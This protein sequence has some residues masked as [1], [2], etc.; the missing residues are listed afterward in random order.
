VDFI[1]DEAQTDAAEIS[2]DA[3]E[4]GPNTILTMAGQNLFPVC[5]TRD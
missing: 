1:A 3:C 2:S 5:Q 4:N